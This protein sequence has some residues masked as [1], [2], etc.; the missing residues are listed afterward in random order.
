M[1]EQV[2]NTGVVAV[3]GGPLLASRL[4]PAA[5]PEP[6]VLRPRLLRALDAG[7]AGP[8]TLVRAPAG[9]GKTTLLASWFRAAGEAGAH[10]GRVGEGPVT[11]AAEGARDAGAAGASPGDFGA[12]DG[13]ADRARPQAAWVSV[14]SGDDGDRLWSYLAAALRA[15][16]EPAAD[17]PGP[18]V[19]GGSPRP[20]QL[21]VLAAALAAR[22]RPVLL[23]LDDLHRI[24]DP[25]ALTGLDFLLRHAEQRLRLVAGARGGLPL[26]VHRLRLA[27]ELT[28]IGPDELAFTGDEVADLLAAHGVTLPAAGV[29]R[30]RE[31]TGGWPAALRLAALALRGQPDPARWAEQFGGDQPD[32]AGY[33]REEVLAGLDPESRDVLRR[34]AV[35]D[36]VCAG[37]VDALTGRADGE[38]ALAGLAGDGGLLR[39]DEGRP[40]WYRCQPLLAEL[41][42]AELG[43]LPADELRDLHL[44]AAGWYAGN[45]RPADGLRH[46]LA[47]GDWDRATELFVAHWP[48]LVP[49]DRD[50]PGGPAPASPPA[51]AVRRD[52]ELALA[53]AAERARA[54]DAGAAA[55][56][57]DSA[58]AAARSL[59][60]PR[61]DRFRRLAAALEVTLA[62]LAGDPAAVRA[63][64]GRLLA[65]RPAL[66]LTPRQPPG[67][68]VTGPAGPGAAAGLLASGPA[69]TAEPR[70]DAAED[71]DVR[72]VAGAA[73]GL[74]DLADG[75]LPAAG[76]AFTRALA[77]AR[78]VGRTRTELVCA[79]RAALLHAVRGELRAAETLARDAL[80]LPPCRGWSCREDCAH[81]YLALALVALH[82]DQPEEAEAHL[83]LAGPATGEP[84]VAAT[85]ALCRAYLLRDAGD[86]AGGHRALAEAR[87]RLADRP[88]ATELASW[89]LAAEADLRGARG[90]LDSARR[91]LADRVRDTAAPPLAIALA[92]VELRAGDARAAGYALPDWDAPE[93]ADWPLPARLDAAVLDAVL[94][95]RAGDERRAGRVLERALDLAGPEGFRRVFTRAEPGVRE[96]LAAHLDAGTAHWPTVSDLVRGADAPA[97]ANPADR[98]AAGLD[99]PLTERE[100]TIL[101]YLQSIL[102]NVEIAAELSLSVN[103][104]KT[105]VR[106][107]YR[108]LDATRRREAVSRARELR[109]I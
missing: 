45:G 32:V 92:R 30:L 53:C 99:E 47:G 28:E 60:A 25:A 43:R 29:R 87:E 7:T 49:Y 101:R 21:E 97:E 57:V 90:D 35:A 67:A 22:E 89:L 56:H 38:Q 18:P 61:R 78:D 100:L 62:R 41:L 63:A 37:L 68:A 33:L 48:E 96:L 52:P 51:E 75:D 15:A 54:G 64:A 10:R 14:E 80:A 106:N 46:A 82:R 39:R 105:H 55:G 50:E 31:R 1:P 94:A 104:V 69:A 66:G 107:I 58:V 71:A 85:A 102:S 79:S 34:S 6:L 88:R 70:G 108:K 16:T 5:P 4:A 24:T 19:P 26:A 77:A 8:V 74:A 91:L 23:V 11:A 83:A 103:T 42:R 81:A 13:P 73:L 76:L 86:L 17:A 12:A 98:G 44:R 93:A 84:T 72:A 36:A 59:P 109:L 3:T 27:G 40:P 95:R 2:R 9:W 65:A 20:D